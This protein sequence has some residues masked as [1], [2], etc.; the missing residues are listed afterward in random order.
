MSKK[1]KLMSSAI[2]FFAEKEYNDESYDAIFEFYYDKG[3]LSAAGITVEAYDKLDWNDK[4]DIR[5]AV[6]EDAECDEELLEYL[7]EHLRP[8]IQDED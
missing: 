5:S 3:D 2:K 7:M 4:V 1:S 8:W 6:V